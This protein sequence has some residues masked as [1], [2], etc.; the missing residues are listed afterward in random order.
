MLPYF[1]R[2]EDQERG[3]DA[4]HGVGGPLA[5]SDV[6]EP[7]PLCEAFI[8]VGAAG[9]LSAQRRFQRADPGGRRLFPAHRAATAAA[10]RPRSAICRQARRRPNLTIETNALASRILFEGRRATGVEYRQGD[11]T[12]TAHASARGDPCRRRVQLAATPAALR[13]SVRPQLLRSHGI[14]VVADMPGVGADLQDHLQVRMQYRCT[15]PITMNDV[16][17]SCRHRIGAGAALRAVQ[18]GPAR[19]RRGLCRRL[20]PHQPAGRDARRAGAFHHLQR[21]DSRRGAASVP[22]LHRLGLPAAAGEPRLRA[23]QVGRSGGGAGDPAALS[24]EPARPRHGGGR[25]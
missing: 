12:R 17:N 8:E 21:R 15:E 11:T 14:D 16:I 20:L 7:H 1:R 23:H 18:Q 24:I 9:G 10:G 25:R 22:G 5:V 13:A 19:H 3:E 4:L 6:C 2:S